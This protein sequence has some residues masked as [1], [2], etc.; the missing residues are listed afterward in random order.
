[1]NA[2]HIPSYLTHLLIPVLKPEKSFK[3]N[4]QFLFVY[5]FLDFFAHLLQQCFL[6]LPSVFFEWETARNGASTNKSMSGKP[7]A[8]HCNCELHRIGA[9]P[10][11]RGSKCM[12]TTSRKTEEKVKRTAT[13]GNVRAVFSSGI[14][15]FREIESVGLIVDWLASTRKNCCRLCIRLST[16]LSANLIA[17]ACENRQWRATFESVAL[18]FQ[19]V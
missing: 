12:A 11:W 9:K 13:E 1:M 8:S 2:K 6:C 4:Q 10:G 3:A 19:Y 7:C 18:V 16:L 5:F 17:V 14:K 15:T